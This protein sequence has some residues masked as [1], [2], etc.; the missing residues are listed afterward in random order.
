M[1]AQTHQSQQLGPLSEHHS[2]SCQED[3]YAQ[4]LPKR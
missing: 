2:T 3:V 1:Y 4:Y